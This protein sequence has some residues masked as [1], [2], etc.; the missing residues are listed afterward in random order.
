MS[1]C[2]N[3]YNRVDSCRENQSAYRR[4]HST[5]TALLKVTSDAL[6]A[7][8]QGKLTLLG[9]LDLS[10]AFDVWITASFLTDSRHR[11]DSPEWYSNW[12][13]S[14]LVGR[15]QYVRYNGSTSS[16]TVMQCGVPQGSVL[17]PLYFVLYTA[18][19]F[20]IVGSWGSSSMDMADDL[21]IYDHCLASDTPQLTN[22]LIQCI[23]I[24]GRWMS[25]NRLRL[26]PS[27]TEFIWLGSTR[28]LARG[29]FDPITIGGENYTT[30]AN[31]S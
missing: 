21:Q 18:D 28:R 27:K 14:Y 20:R 10:A 17:G 16:V 1:G 23:E 4:S 29:T 30:I 9:M 31:G 26:N 8:D 25:S 5:E 13:R 6:I 19:A 15:R 22:R 7:A 2:L 24:V 12:M 3:T 11:S